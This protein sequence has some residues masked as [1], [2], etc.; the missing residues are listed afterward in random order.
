MNEEVGRVSLPVKDE[1]K[2]EEPT[3]PENDNGKDENGGNDKM[4]YDGRT[5]IDD[6]L[7]VR[8]FG[9][10]GYGG[11]GYG[12]GGYGG[13]HTGDSYLSAKAHAEGTGVTANILA[14][15]ALSSQGLDRLS[16]GFEATFRSMQFNNLSKEHN[17]LERRVNDQN[18]A[19]IGT[20]N[21]VSREAAKCCCE[22]KLLAET[23]KC[24]ILSAIAAES[25]DT[26]NR[27]LAA[28][29]AELIHL[30]TVNALDDKDGHGRR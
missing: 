2:K 23:N 19:L 22:A 27:E 24:E 15:R 13:G 14:N 25:K 8:G 4:P 26:I 21:D 3:M 29:N 30:R 20:L 16:E 5:N 17:D 9:G 28:A 1:P 10:Y 18:A 7:T 11:G 6:F 12:G